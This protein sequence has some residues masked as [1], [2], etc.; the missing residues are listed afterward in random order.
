MDEKKFI[1]KSWDFKEDDTKISNHGFHTY[2]AMMIPQV[3]RRLIETYGADA[4]V[5]CDP[6]MGTGTSIL[7][8]KLHSNFEIAYG[9]DINPLARLIAKV[10][11]TPIDAD[12]LV[13]IV[14]MVL[15]NSATEI[16]D[17]KI[18]NKQIK[19]PDFKNI[20][21]WFKPEV[22]RDLVIIKKNIESIWNEQDPISI[23][24]RDFLLVSFSETVRLV[25]NTRNSEF[26]L[27]RMAESS[28]AKHNPD[29]FN[30]FKDKTLKNVERLTIFNKEAKNCKTVILNEDSRYRTS[31]PDDC[32]DLIVTSPPYG[33][34]RTTVAYGQFS[35]LSLEWMEFDSKEVRSIDKVS[36][37][38]VPVTN[39]DNT[40]GSPSLNKSIRDIRNI[41]ELRAKEVLS[42]YVD[43]YE[44]VK[45]INRFMKR[46]GYLCFVVGNRTV[47]KQQIPTDDI[48]VELFQSVGSYNHE[49]TIIR[50]I[51]MKRMPKENSPT[52]VRGDKSST[53]NHEYIIILNKK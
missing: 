28:L 27:Y 10:K 21:Y 6:F 38:G 41:D 30:T 40:L 7:E 35:R 53:M 36:L 29:T 43:F 44:C 42:F 13:E 2:P 11:V 47:K 49:K 1:D 14:S 34:S 25:S 16:A 18:S 32:V 24:I 15:E 9:I 20:D 4:K 33:D 23:D 8:A 46:G 17:Y 37:G 51:P 19:S 22:I 39:L 12:K 48:I 5:L 26:K 3:A 50:N 52:N 45:E 31:I